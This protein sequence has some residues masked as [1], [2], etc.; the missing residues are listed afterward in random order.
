MDSKS[1][2]FGPA[3]AYGD[4]DDSGQ[5][6]VVVVSGWFAAGEFEEARGTLEL[7]ALTDANLEVRMVLQLANS[8]DDSSFVN[9]AIGPWRST[10]D[11]HYPDDWTG[12]V[13][14]TK[15][16]QIGRV[17]IEGRKK[18]GTGDGLA[19]V[20]VLGRMDLKTC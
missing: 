9:V 17:C 2:N 5:E 7:R 14:S 10:E 8:P 19:L 15:N 4:S 20:T 1:M 18:T 3:T 12:I 11:I 6:Q 13:N 16:K